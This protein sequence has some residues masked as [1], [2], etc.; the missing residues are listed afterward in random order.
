M[1]MTERIDLEYDLSK[2]DLI[3]ALRTSISLGRYEEY[4]RASRRKTLIA[5]LWI[6]PVFPFVFLGLQQAWN[7]VRHGRATLKPED[8]IGFGLCGVVVGILY[9][10][11]ASQLETHRRAVL[12]QLLERTRGGWGISS[13]GRIRLVIT[14]EGLSYTDPW[15]TATFAWPLVYRAEQHAGA[16]EIATLS[17]RNIPSPPPR[18]RASDRRRSAPPS[19]PITTPQADRIASCSITW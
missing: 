11:W 5:A 18:R 15:T 7:L 16:V 10:L 1:P 12:D 9:L 14:P 3:D 8:L 4:V 13:T 2:K 17:E 6:A 19:S